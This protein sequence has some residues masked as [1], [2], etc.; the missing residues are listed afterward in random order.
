MTKPAA[1][2]LLVLI[3]AVLL[4]VYK[5]NNSPPGLYSDEAAYGYNAYSLLTTGHDEYAKSWPFALKSFGDYKPPM[6][7]WLTIPS[8]ATFG[9]SEFA[10][11]LPSALAGVAS[12]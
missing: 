10:V 1:L 12:V 5:L 6:T 2:F 9:L 4:R 3:F 11:R 8:I 7:A